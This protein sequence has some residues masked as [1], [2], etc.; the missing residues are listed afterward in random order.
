MNAKKV[1]KTS[2]KQRETQ[3]DRFDR[4]YKVVRERICLLEYA[5]G[6]L[7]NEGLL[8]H[9]FGVS[10]TPMR[11]VLQ[12][13]NYEGLLETRNGVGTIV[14]D[15]NFKTFKD[16]YELRMRLS[17]MLG[18]LSPIEPTP[19]TIAGIKRLRKRVDSLKECPKDLSAY[20]RL[21]NEL[22]EAVL[23]LIGNEALR[24][25]TDLL[26]YRVARIWLTFLDHLDWREEI[27]IMQHEV[28]EILRALEIGDMRGVGNTRRQYLYMMLTR[29]S[30][31]L[32][33]V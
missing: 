25:V 30:R 31:Y 19:E 11:N 1:A 23:E 32:V 4:I 13:L 5:P 10:R 22:H 24:E 2:T 29:I 16:I 7:L 17:E 9:E 12:R 8:A 6:T 27:E 3:S 26:Y 28:S 14:T 18:V 21:C 15:V 33:N 20:A